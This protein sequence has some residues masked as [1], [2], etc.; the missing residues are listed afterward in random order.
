LTKNRYL[1]KIYERFS[2]LVETLH[3]F[4]GYGALEI[5]VQFD[6]SFLDQNFNLLGLNK[7]EKT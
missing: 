5:R 3:V 1:L 4:W 2:L 6:Y 7:F